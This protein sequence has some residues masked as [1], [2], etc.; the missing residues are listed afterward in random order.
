MILSE[1]E[2]KANSFAGQVKN[3]I[4]LVLHNL[5]GAHF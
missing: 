2:F 5:F 1:D 3:S 4:Q